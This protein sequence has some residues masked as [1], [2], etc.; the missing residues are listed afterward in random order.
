M[1]ALLLLLAPQAA[2]LDVALDAMAAVRPD[3]AAGYAAARDR[4]LAFGR[5]A[6]P[7][8]Q[9]RGAADQWTAAGWVRALAAESCRLRLADPGLAAAVDRPAGLDPAQ[10]RQF[11]LPE[12]ICNAELAR[13]GSAAVPLLLERWRW[14][15]AEHPFSAGDAGEKER[16]ALRSAILQ[17]G[18]ARARHF[19]A[20]VLGTAGLPDSWRG[21]AAVSLGMAGGTGALPIL[22]RTLDDRA[23][24]VAVRE[25][26]ARGLGRVADPAA[27]DAIR[28]RLGEADVRR[29]L[30]QALGLLGSA[31]GWDARGAA[32]A[33]TADLVRRG[34][35]DALM[36]ALRQ[37]PEE[38]AAIGTALSM[39]AWPDSLGAVEALASDATATAAQRAAAGAVL[40]GLKQ[41][42]ARRT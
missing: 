34:C 42:L 35:A 40:P 33:P 25:A 5:D 19:L 12:P 24:P 29:S 23:Q 10:Y 30:L 15:F 31:W 11:R 6:I 18:D 32:R 14:T 2:D 1:I 41:S 8:L 27:L 13:R 37:A 20:E 38:S 7:A 3:N 28:S 39:T 9:A 16:E 4:V 21:Q 17:Q 22:T 36:G 26:C